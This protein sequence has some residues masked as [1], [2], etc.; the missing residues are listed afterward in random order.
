MKPL[1][2]AFAGLYGLSVSAATLDVSLL[3][4]Q[5]QPLGN[6]VL[7]LR[8]DAPAAA[9]TDAVV[10]QRD[11]QFLPRVLAVR[12][13]TTVSFPNSDNIRH[14]V[15]S[16]SPAKR[17]ELRLYQGT[18]S[19]PVVF[20]KPGLVVLGCNI[21]DWMLGY[22]YVTDDPWFGVSDENGRIRLELPAGT[23]QATLW[24]PQ[25]ADMLPVAA[26]S[27]QVP[28]Q[29]LSQRYPLELVGDAAQALPTQPAPSAFGEAIRK[30]ASD[31]QP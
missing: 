18:P 19:E 30:A 10:D 27:L 4:S 12:T 31:V 6:A 24:H 8:G 28:E 3:D 23:Y 29:G 15:Y 7:T 17:F 9:S 22:V 20:D 2:F 26:G 14:H 25:V 16:F 11:K 5:G 21:H 1:I 13:G